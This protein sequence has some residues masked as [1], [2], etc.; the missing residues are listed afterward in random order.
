MNKLLLFFA[1]CFLTN[2]SSIDTSR[3]AP[4]YGEAFKTFK[5]A[6]FGFED[7]KISPSVINNIPYAS[8]LLKIG[9][10]PT[11]LL[12]LESKN[13][14]IETW[15]SADKVILLIKNGRIIRTSGLQN[16]LDKLISPYSSFKDLKHDYS[17]GPY[18]TYLSY[19]KPSLINLEIE[20]K[21]RIRGIEKVKLFNR[22]IN[23]TLI[24]EEMVNK[25]IGWKRVNK[26]WVD[27]E[28]F[29]WKSEQYISPKLPK[30]I[31][32]IT[33]KPS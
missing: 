26:Y 25:T 16:N 10:G 27:E 11:G 14:E 33:K 20:I 29:V 18:K 21:V 24:E 2:C 32:E 1:I 19:D 23:L 13:D 17:N 12:I 9:K 7:N 8:S 3:I 4:G 6:V 22:E 15:I 28:Y 5:N 30:F 31:L